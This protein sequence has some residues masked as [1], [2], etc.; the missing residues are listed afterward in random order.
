MI[1]YQVLVSKESR[2]YQNLEVANLISVAEA[3]A[4]AEAKISAIAVAEVM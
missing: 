4:V 2:Y 3:E 1:Y